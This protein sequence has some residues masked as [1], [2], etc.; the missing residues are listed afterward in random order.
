MSKEFVIIFVIA[1]IYTTMSVT[2]NIIYILKHHQ[3]DDGIINIKNVKSPKEL[4][5]DTN[6]D[7]FICILGFTL[8]MIIFPINSICT[9]RYWICNIGGKK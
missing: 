5:K 7:M 1:I 4:Y 2:F 6:W 9:F 8:A 3:T